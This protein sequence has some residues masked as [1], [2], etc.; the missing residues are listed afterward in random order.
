MTEQ[1]AFIDKLNALLNHDGLL[2][3]TSVVS[4]KE[5]DYEAFDSKNDRLLKKR[6]TEKSFKELF[7]RHNFKILKSKFWIGNKGMEIFARK[8]AKLS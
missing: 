8:S 5:A 2:F 3:I 6:L 4:E 1:D 7:L